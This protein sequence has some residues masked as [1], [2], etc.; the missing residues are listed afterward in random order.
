MNRLP[1]LPKRKY[2]HKPK[3]IDFSANPD[4]M[5]AN[6]VDEHGKPHFDLKLDEEKFFST[7]PIKSKQSK[8][9]EYYNNNLWAH[10]HDFR[11]DG[12]TKIKNIRRKYRNILS[13]EL[14]LKKIINPS[15]GIKD[16]VSEPP[17]IFAKRN[18]NDKYRYEQLKEINS[19]KDRLAKDGI[20]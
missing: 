2:K 11:Q 18:Y 19:L 7:S 10:M 15:P 13:P 17:I 12:K 16:T 14:S 1:I 4:E 5:N 8:L 3:L 9:R 20:P 6:Q